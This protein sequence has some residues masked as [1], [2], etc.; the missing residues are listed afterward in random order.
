M[1]APARPRRL[2]AWARLTLLAAAL[3][4]SHLYAADLL[5][6]M[7]VD[8]SGGVLSPT[9]VLLLLAYVLLL[10]LP[11]MPGV[12]V[13]LVLL[14]GFGAAAAPF[15]WAATVLGLT[16]A[17][18]VGRTVAPARVAAMFDLLAMHRA[19]RALRDV[20][21]DDGAARRALIVGALP[22]R[23]AAAVLGHRHVMLALLLNLPG[24]ALIGGGGGIAGMSGLT[25]LHRPWPFVL[26]VALAVAPV[27]LAVA[28]LGDLPF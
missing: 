24:N 7:K 10:A 20:A 5:A 8:T 25:R 17:Y 28:L 14:A 1:T 27:P 13:G 4:A 22:P 23:L 9:I 26:T 3:L 6:M 21:A 19:S 16:L 11:F 2:P 15:V 18:L 12:E